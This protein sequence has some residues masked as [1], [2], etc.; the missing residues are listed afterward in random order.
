MLFVLM[1]SIEDYSNTLSFSFLIHKKD[2]ISLVKLQELSNVYKGKV[3]ETD[4]AELLKYSKQGMYLKI[5]WKQICYPGTRLRVGAM[6]S[7]KQRI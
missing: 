3:L 5:V 6:L 4:K 1:K 7:L 2:E